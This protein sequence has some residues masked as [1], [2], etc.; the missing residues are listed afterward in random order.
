MHIYEN[1]QRCDAEAFF[2]LTGKCQRK[3]LAKTARLVSLTGDGYLYP[4]IAILVLNLGQGP[5]LKF[6]YVGLM[7]YALE[8]TLYLLLKNTIKRPRPAD[9]HPGANPLVVPSDKFSFP[10]GHTAAAFVMASL[11][12]CFFPAVAVFAY[13]WAFLIGIS[14]VLIGVHYPTDILAGIVLGLSATTLS[15][16]ILG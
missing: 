13:S 3:L 15:L 5:G 14:R 1:L 9:S 4:V 10:S 16:T 11:L 6:L 8:L 12:D 7:A 2:W